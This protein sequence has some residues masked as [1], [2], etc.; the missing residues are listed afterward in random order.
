MRLLIQRHVIAVAV[1]LAFVARAETEDTP[2]V[3]RPQSAVSSAPSKADAVPA[4]NNKG[5]AA[6]QLYVS[7]CAKCHKFYDPAKYSDAQWARWM[8]KMGKK[9]KLS[10]EQQRELAGYI[11]GKYRS[12]GNAALTTRR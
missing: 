7:K 9:A 11:Q 12:N 10:P 8:G 4:G 3:R 1:V 6:E 5:A 2:T